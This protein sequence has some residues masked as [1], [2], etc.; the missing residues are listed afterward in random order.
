MALATNGVHD[1]V[2][3]NTDEPY[4]VIGEDDFQDWS[5]HTFDGFQG[6]VTLHV[7][8]AKKGRKECKEI[9]NRVYELLNDQDIAVPNHKTVNFRLGLN[10]IFKDSDGKTHRGLMRFD[11][12]LGGN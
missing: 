1:S 12:I 9:Q 3:D 4:I 7:W 10:E 11:F 8:S 5:S 6:D 2:P